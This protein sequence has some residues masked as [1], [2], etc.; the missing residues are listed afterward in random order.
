MPQG[1]AKQGYILKIK[2]SLYRPKQSPRNFFLQLKGQ[3]KRVGLK[4]SNADQCLF[5]SNVICLVYVDDTLFCEQN[6]GYCN[7]HCR[8]TEME[9]EEEDDLASFL[10]VHI[11]RHP[12]STI[13]LTQKGF[14]N[15]VIKALIH[16]FL[17]DGYVDADFAG[18]WGYKDKQDPSC[19][20]SCTGYVICI[21]IA[22]CSRSVN[23]K[24]TLLLPQW[25]QG[26]PPSPWQCKLYSHSN[27]LLWPSSKASVLLNLVV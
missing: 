4:P 26:I 19:I 10:G 20:K 21:I 23:F 14:I 16:N 1:F 8:S 7:H 13:H 18:M 5:V 15:R 3:L 25:K 17:I 9:L 12:D 2:K 27:I 6:E 22:L 24:L 11:K